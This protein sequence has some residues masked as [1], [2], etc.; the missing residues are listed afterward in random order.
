MKRKYDTDGRLA[1]AAP[2]REFLYGVLADGPMLQHDVAEH[3]KARGFSRWQLKRA[4]KA[5]GAIAF[6][7]RGENLN[8]PW[9]WAMPKHAPP[10]ARHGCEGD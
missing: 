3:G 9:L 7:R 8:S 6:K 1:R 5:I 10:R 2:I 4:H